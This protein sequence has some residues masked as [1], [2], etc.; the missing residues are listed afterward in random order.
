MS[1][2]TTTPPVAPAAPAA[3]AAAPMTPADCAQRLKE[4]FPALFTGP[5]KPLKLRIQAD[6]QERAPGVFTKQALSGF[7]RRHT[8]STSYLIA[9]TKAPHRFDLDGQP[10]GEI[11]DE[12]RKVAADELTRRRA[13]HEAR[14][15]EE[16]GQRRERAQLLRDFERTTLT[17]ANFCA[18]KGIAADQLETVLAQARQEAAERPPMPS[19]TRGEGRPGRPPHRQDRHGAPAP[20]RPRDEGQRRDHRPARGPRG[21]A[22]APR[23]QGPKKPDAPKP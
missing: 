12:H 9:L 11:T 3:S 20:G 10:A 13:N 5:A 7:F 16:E 22:A 1:D 18:L 14:R 8:G 17:P 19:H 6:I 21:D 23:P 2:D 4:L 15:A